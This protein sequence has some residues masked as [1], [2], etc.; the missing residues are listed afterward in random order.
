LNILFVHQNMPGQFKHLAPQLA[1]TK[2]NNVVFITKREGLD[3]QGVRR[4]NYTIPRAARDTTH[5]YVRLFENSV[6]YGQQVV[7]SCHGLVKEGFRPDVIVA[8]P[9]WGEALFMKDVFPST[10]LINFCEFYYRG[11][12]AD[13]GFDPEEP[14][15][16]DDV[17][18]A[19]ARN[20]HL[21]LSL[22]SCDAGFS[23]T[24][25]Q[26]SS[27]PAVFHDKI[28]V[29]FDGID[30]DYIKPDPNATFA[31][32]DG[33]E[34]SRMDE[35]VTY[36]VRNLEPYRGFPNF[37]RS[38]PKLLELRPN[39]TVLVVGGDDVSYGRAPAEGKTWRETMLEEVP[40]D[41]GRVHFLGK[42]PY[43]RYRSVLQVSSAH[44]YLTRPFVL[45]WSCIEAMAAGC[46]IV[47][48]RT[49]PVEE[50]IED[51]V[52]GFLVDFHSPDAIARKTAEVLDAGAALDPIR[53][54]A[55]ETVLERYSLSKCLPRQLKLIH[56]VARR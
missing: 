55:R 54:A 19:R 11:R 17:L 45:S 2:D 4:V 20:A 38:L 26:K 31:L 10:P 21:L 8:H 41:L 53:Q 34:L 48:S 39:A 40:L 52:N 28:S 27:H 14:A 42:L 47:G 3:L 23:P 1:A 12:G 35:I 50:V 36:S 56:D 25:W 16:I 44:I 15:G 33:R 37:I 24:E 46:L 9:G 49:P 43:A 32:P 6:I 13:V 5:H 7:R 30:T 18:R 29:I 51:G 22:E